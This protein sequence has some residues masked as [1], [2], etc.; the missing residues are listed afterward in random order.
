LNRI[1]VDVA[2]PSGNSNQIG[3]FTFGLMPGTV[4]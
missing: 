4:P 3:R 2:G 1:A